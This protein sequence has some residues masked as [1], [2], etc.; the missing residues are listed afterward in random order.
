MAD[1]AEL[2][3][4]VEGSLPTFKLDSPTMSKVGRNVVAVIVENILQQRTIDGGKIKR[5]SPFTRLRKARE[6][7]L[8]L[9]LVDKVRRFVLPSNYVV[10]ATQT[11]VTVAVPD[12]D[13]AIDL[14][15]RGYTGWIGVPKGRMN[16]VL[17]P[18]RD[19]IKRKRKKLKT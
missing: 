8:A 2:K 5:N 1:G 18:I 4:E 3:R 11:G 7:K 6:G 9:S 10:S 14:Q 12:A 19:L 17:K 13:L 15:K 16:R